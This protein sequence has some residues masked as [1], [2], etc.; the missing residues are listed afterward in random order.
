MN[1]HQ[2]LAI[3]I[4]PF[5]IILGYIAADYYLAASNST[6]TVAQEKSQA[7]FLQHAC[8]LHTVACRLTGANIELVLQLNSAKTQL[9]VTANKPLKGVTL[10]LD[11]HPP[12]QLRSINHNA[13][14]WQMAITQSTSYTRLKLV[15]ATAGQFYFAEIVLSPS[16]H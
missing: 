11:Q 14:T 4:A 13:Q 6:S 3:L 16:S 8:D 1:A 9:W 15:S 2:K 5:L 10:A 7:L 12:Q